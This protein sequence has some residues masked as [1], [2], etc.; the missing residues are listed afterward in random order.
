M[1]SPRLELVEWLDANSNLSSLEE[2]DLPGL[3]H[4]TTVGFV[5]K[6]TD[7][8]LWLVAERVLTPDNS[9]DV[10]PTPEWRGVTVLP[11]SLITKRRRL[12]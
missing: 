12:R 1:S 4:I 5:A 8:I 2:R 10:E 7:D 3:A 11:K 9:N 6:E